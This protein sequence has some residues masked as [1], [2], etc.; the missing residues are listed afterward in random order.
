M[1]GRSLRHFQAKYLVLDNFFWHHLWLRIC[2]E[3]MKLIIFTL[4]LLKVLQSKAYTLTVKPIEVFQT[5]PHGR[6]GQKELSKPTYYRYININSG[7]L[8]TLTHGATKLLD[9]NHW[10]Y[11][12]QLVEN[13]FLQKYDLLGLTGSNNAGV[14]AS[15][16]IIQNH[17][18]RIPILFH[19]ILELIASIP[20]ILSPMIRSRNFME[21]NINWMTII[22]IPTYNCF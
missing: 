5:M 7:F 6:F 18:S 14:V 1:L 11:K 20:T 10:K 15:I 22:V 3:N 19:T 16:P 13:H 2:S 21:K 4:I 12:K 8:G 9:P 17:M